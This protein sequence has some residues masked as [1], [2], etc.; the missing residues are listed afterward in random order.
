MEFSSSS[1]L[2]V[3]F[4]STEKVVGK[5]IVVCDVDEEVYEIPLLSEITRTRDKI[6]RTMIALRII[7]VEEV[8]GCS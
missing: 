6:K 8:F 7:T 2:E 1:L 5:T 4:F 3:S